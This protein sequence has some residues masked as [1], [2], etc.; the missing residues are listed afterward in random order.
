MCVR[1]SGREPPDVNAMI[2]V[3]NGIQITGNFVKIF[4]NRVE[5]GDPC[6][7]S[8][9]RDYLFPEKTNLHQNI[10]TTFFAI[11]VIL[12]SLKNHLLLTILTS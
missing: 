6:I 1:L 11:L 8:K 4:I 5:R 9:R 3:E 2:S 10:A 12:V 7:L